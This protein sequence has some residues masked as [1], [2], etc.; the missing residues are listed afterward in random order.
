VRVNPSTRCSV[1]LQAPRALRASS[2]GEM[3]AP[4]DRRRAPVSVRP[5]DARGTRRSSSSRDAGQSIAPRSTQLRMT[6]A[7]LPCTMGSSNERRLQRIR[8]P[9][10]TDWQQFERLCRDL[11]AS[12]WEDPNT[13]MNG[14]DGQEQ[15][16][17]D[18]YGQPG[19]GG[20]Y[21]AVQ[22]KRK[23]NVL[24]N[25][26]ISERELRVEVA[27]AKT[28]TPPLTGDFIL[29]FTG[30][31]DAKILAVARAIAAEHHAAGLFNV[32][33][34]SWEDIQERLGEHPDVVAKHY[35]AL[36]ASFRALEERVLPEPAS[37]TTDAVSLPG[38][39]NQARSVIVA[40][41]YPPIETE[42]R[43]EIQ[44]VRVALKEGHARVA[45]AQAEGLRAR[46][47]AS[48]SPESRARILILIA[49]ARL[50]LGEDTEASS[51][52]L[53]A[54]GHAPDSAYVQAQAALGHSLLGNDSAAMAWASKA[55]AQN[56]TD[57]RRP[58]GYN[59]ICSFVLEL[60]FRVR[61]RTQLQLVSSIF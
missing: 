22:C 37:P 45:L 21:S 9:P 51:L 26:E 16:G 15:A 49:H 61:L 48:A 50:E 52:L 11:W 35:S 59:S 36:R 12:I 39:S 28:F 41:D 29:A 38:H 56:P 27:K 8:L 25:A 3:T 6:R 2:L 55:L 17:V 1:R 19:V 30:K 20:G 60:R 53:E 34:Y 47:W 24:D 5:N 58:M 18:I 54:A 23:G 57:M 43:A 40:D 31:R 33:V 14:R 44:M 32:V 7:G 10:P 4:S 13:Q 46:I 42:H